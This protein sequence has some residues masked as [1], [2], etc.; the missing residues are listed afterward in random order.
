[1]NSSTKVRV[2]SVAIALQSVVVLGYPR[3]IAVSPVRVVAGLIKTRPGRITIGPF[4]EYSHSIAAPA[5]ISSEGLG[6]SV[7]ASVELARQAW[8]RLDYKAALDTLDRARRDFHDSPALLAAYGSVYLKAEEPSRA[9]QYLDRATQLDPGCREAMLGEAEASLLDRNYAAS[10]DWLRRVLTVDPDS[11]NASSAHLLQARVCL[12]NGDRVR[13]ESEAAKAIEADP[14]NGHALYFMAYIRSA[15]R[16]PAQVRSLAQRALEI[17]PYLAGA[18]RLLSQYLNGTT[19]YSQAV[20]AGAM[21]HFETGKALEGQGR[22][23]EAVTEYEAAANAQPGYY[24]ALIALASVD[25]MQREYNK[26]VVAASR[27]LEVDPEGAIANMEVAYAQ[28]G[29]AEQ[30]RTE[31]GATDYSVRFYQ[32]GMEPV[33]GSLVRLVFPDFDKLDD[34]GRFVLGKS[35]SGLACFLPALASASAR[36]YLLRI[37]QGVS[38]CAGFKELRDRTT[39]DGRYYASI[40]GVGG[41]VALSGIEYLDEASRGGFNAIAHE[42]AHQVHETAMSSEDQNAIRRLYAAAVREGRALDYYAAANEFE[43]FATGYEA[44]VSKFKRPGAT[45]T[46][47]HTREELKAR[48]P[49]LFRF[50]TK[51]ADKSAQAGA[52]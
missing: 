26:A 10:E 35:V 41:R 45:I 47:R 44:F 20:D 51:M 49:G 43:Y 5:P 29:L 40:R 46:A 38:E 8:T 23:G 16:R 52:D 18:R 13:A 39:F 17:D 24:R 3:A 22:I 37:D 11:K 12:E 21:H 4:S 27:A 15:Q 31:I 25:L 7:E 14:R 19:G 42:F 2:V 32:D 9:R 48:D 33:K 6:N 36:H 50:L 1:M 28:I 34:R 30:S